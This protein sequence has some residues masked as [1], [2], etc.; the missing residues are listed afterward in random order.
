MS[1]TVTPT[2]PEFVAE[3]SGVDVA[4]PLEPADRQTIEDAINRY[5]VVVFRG[6]TLDDEKQVA[7]A[8]NFGPIESSALKLRHRD[9]KHRIESSQVADISNLDGDGNVMKPDARRRLDG[10]AN[11]LWHTDASFRAVPGAL[12]MLYAH[13]I[14]EEGGDTEFADMRAAYDALPEAKKKELE[15]LVAEHSIWRSR[16]QLGVVQYTAEERASL[17]PVP[18]R[19][20]R[21]HPGSHRKTLYL[22][23]HASHILG[24]PVADGRLIILDLIEHATQPRF[25][26]AHRWAKGDLVIW[27]NRCTM[28]RARP[29]DTTR[30]RDLRRV[31]T[32]D[33][34]ST[35]EQAA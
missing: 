34:A 13:V 17:P 23:A 21:T 4:Q 31:T 2:H 11:R 3:I 35:I 12:S 25:V 1:I 19:V 10:L 29:F 5:A 28:H 30:V 9:I 27:D 16:E 8:G 15:G 32:R 7:F 24:L 22:A 26:H 20:V 14:P 6:Q 33:V 18:Q